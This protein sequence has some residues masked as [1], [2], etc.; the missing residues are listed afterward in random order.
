[1]KI[2]EINEIN[3]NPW[4]QWKSMK[5]HE[6]N[7]INENPW[8]PCPCLQ[9]IYHC[10]SDMYVSMHPHVH[11]E[12]Q[13]LHKLKSMSIG[14]RPGAS[15]E[16]HACCTGQA[17]PK[18]E[19]AANWHTHGK[20]S[21]LCKPLDSASEGKWRYLQEGERGKVTDHI[22]EYSRIY[23]NIVMLWW[24]CWSQIHPKAN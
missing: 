24:T 17:R 7:E 5:I 19:G 20:S 23:G 18:T 10:Q 2:H 15:M 14:I 12:L 6:I 11:T 16:N 1:M 22:M 13:S 8:N 9:H 3:E 21:A 4:N